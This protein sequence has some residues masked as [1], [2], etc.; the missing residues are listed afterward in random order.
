L[1]RKDFKLS[2]TV[3][4][5]LPDLEILDD[6]LNRIIEHA[7]QEYPLESCGILAGK[8]GR[9]TEFYPMANKKRSSSCYLMEPEE[10]LRVFQ[11]IEKHGLGLLAIYHSHPH[12]AAFPSQQDV[13]YAFYPDSLI[14]IISLMEKEVP[15]I[16]AFQIEKG[17]IERKAVKVTQKD[18]KSI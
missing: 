16:G 8:N 13:D 5:N 3:K 11:E 12:T 9:I 4:K 1:G 15:Q 10:Q 6:L 7:R 18:E 2:E 14:L 17:K